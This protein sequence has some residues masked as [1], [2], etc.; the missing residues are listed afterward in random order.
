MTVAILYSGGLDSLIMKAHAKR[1]GYDYTTIWVNLG[2]P[3]AERE[4]Q[5]VQKTAPETVRIDCPIMQAQGYV[6]SAGHI[7]PAR[8]LLLATIA[9]GFGNIVWLGA[10]L[11]ETHPFGNRDKSTEWMHL[12]SGMLTYNFLPV[13]PETI[14]EYPLGLFT[15]SGAISLALTYGLTTADFACATSCHSASGDVVPCGVC[16]ACFHR[17]IGMSLN[18]VYESYQV[19]PWSS[20]LVSREVAAMKVAEDAGDVIHYHPARI[21]DTREALSRVGVAWV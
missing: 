9:A 14:V 13:R 18:G 15:K 8:N 11:G 1:Y 3:Y 21:A 16:V 4:W 5:A 2:Q 17:W 10:L 19:D 12:T 20:D 6:G 7:V